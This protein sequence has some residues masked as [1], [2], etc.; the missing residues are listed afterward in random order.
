ML[1]LQLDGIKDLA[2]GL[3]FGLTLL[4]IG[5][6]AEQV[7]N[8][9][10]HNVKVL[11]QTQIHLPERLTHLNHLLLNI[12]SILLRLLLIALLEDILTVLGQLVV[13]DLLELRNL[14]VVAEFFVRVHVVIESV[15]ELVLD[16]LGFELLVEVILTVVTVL[17]ALRGARLVTITADVLVIALTL[18]VLGLALRFVVNGRAQ[19]VVLYLSSPFIVLIGTK[20]VALML[21][22]AL[23]SLIVI[24]L[25]ILAFLH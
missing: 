24:G 21:Q 12:L 23:V 18:F 25:H 10:V 3:Q 11:A 20:F 9:S 1:Q 19:L 5:L 15:H 16:L 22:R 14:N 2:Q 7:L 13:T 6:T 17:T 8:M 4:F